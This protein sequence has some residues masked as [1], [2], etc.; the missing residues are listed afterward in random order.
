VSRAAGI[1]AIAG[2][3]AGLTAPQTTH[4]QSATVPSTQAAASVVA[5]LSDLR[6]PPG[7]TIVAF[8]ADL[9][10][11]RMMAVS[12]EGTLHVA[13]RGD[14]VA[15]P[16]SDRDGRA[17]PRVVLSGLANAHTLAFRDGYLYVGTTPAVVRVR[18]ANGSPVGAPENFVELPTS[19]PAVHVSRS[20]LFGRDGRLYV[21]IGSS[22]NVCIEGDP[23]RTTIQ[24]FDADGRNGRTFA[25]GLH[26]AVGLDW[27][28]RT[29]RLWATDTGQEQLGD[30]VPPEEI[31]LI[32]DGKH[33]GFPF[34]YGQNV[35]SHVPEIA[36]AVRTVQASGV[37]PPVLE[38]PAH[39]T[40]LGMTFYTGTSFPEEYRTMYVT[41]H[42]S[43]TRSTKNG[44][45]VIRVRMKDGRPVASDDFATG[46]LKDGL[47]SGRPRG[48]ITG[49]DDALY[50]SDDNKGFIYRIAYRP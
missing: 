37:A 12:P 18:W 2:V 16:D 50:V 49:P 35:E 46:W 27:D 43:T 21:G 1:L 41:L 17:E 23:R 38:L 29:G 34:F 47:V 14:V 24:V 42:G 4:G 32:E 36:G 11:A 19:T 28:P 7:F 10:G 25:A 44:Y 40:P 9:Q 31:N 30:D 26:N 48:I 13:R 8:A 22:C 3:T 6:V 15:L 20:I 33:F 45:K 39:S 5:P